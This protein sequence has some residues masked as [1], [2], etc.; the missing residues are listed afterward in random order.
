MAMGYNGMVTTTQKPR[1]FKENYFS[2]ML[3]NYF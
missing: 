3:F 1:L 2:S